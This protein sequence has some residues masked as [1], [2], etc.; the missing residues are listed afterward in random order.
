[1]I[2]ETNKFSQFFARFL[3]SR[4]N[5]EHFEEKMTLIDFVLSMLRNRTNWLDKCL[6]SLVSEDRPKSDMVNGP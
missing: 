2:L 3:K 4:L 6:Q 5:V 1:M